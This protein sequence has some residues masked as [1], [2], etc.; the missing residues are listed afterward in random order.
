MRFTGRNDK[1][2]LKNRRNRRRKPNSE[3]PERMTMDHYKIDT[4]TTEDADK[5][6]GI[7][8]SNTSFLENHLGVTAV[9]EEFI[10]REMAEMKNIGFQSFVIRNNASDII[11][12]CDLKMAEEVYLSLLMID[13]KHKRRGTGGGIYRQLEQMFK[14]KGVRTVRI[15]VVDGYEDNAVGFWEK[16][17]FTPCEKI[18]LE[19]NGCQSEAV[20]MRKSI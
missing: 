5:V 1:I 3:K 9:S 4:M 19:W 11:G 14:E 20:V 7:Y 17:G 18:Q 12:I 13:G 10:L 15:D 8:N 6:S 16:Q 2:E